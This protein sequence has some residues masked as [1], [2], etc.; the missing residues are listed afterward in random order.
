MGE[1]GMRAFTVAEA[2][3]HGFGEGRLRHRRFARP[4][5]GVRVTGRFDADDLR[6]RCRALSARMPPGQVFSHQTAAALHGIPLPASLTRPDA[7]L[8]IS[9]FEP[10]RAPQLRGVRSH[11]LKPTGQR[12][13]RLDGL[14]VLGVEDTWAQLSTS[15][16]AEDLVVA[17]DWLI[18]GDEPYS[19][20]PPPTSLEELDQAIARRGRMRGVRAL[21][22]ARD[23]SRYG[24]LSPQETRLRLLLAHAGLPEPALNHRVRDDDGSL[25]AMVD[26][27][28]PDR[29]IAIEYLGDH[30]RTTTGVYRDD[31]LRR[32]RLAHH[33]WSVLYTTSHDLAAPAFLTVRLRRLLASTGF[34]S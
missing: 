15:L 4:F 11:E 18:T 7:D 5:H 6:A 16:S 20:S 8:H 21:R 31:I 12:V 34:P 32:E 3:R 25:V 30:H 24:P 33:G 10:D 19:G 29:R 1:D 9:V 22:E 28:Y 23:R 26:L 17:A 27:A 14:A 2:A 13:V